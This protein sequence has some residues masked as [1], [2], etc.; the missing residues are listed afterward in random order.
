MEI[1][2][3]RIKLSVELIP[4]NTIG[5]ASFSPKSQRPNSIPLSLAN[6]A[7]SVKVKNYNFHIYYT[8]FLCFCKVKIQFIFKLDK[9]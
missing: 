7:K 3:L 9:K 6:N 8:R 4:S 1:Y 2:A 5:K